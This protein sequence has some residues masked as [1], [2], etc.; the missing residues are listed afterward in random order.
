MILLKVV[1]NTKKSINRKIK[2]FIETTTNLL[3]KYVTL[4]D[5]DYPVSALWFVYLLWLKGF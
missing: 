1:L 3:Q 5:F 4:A 2:Q